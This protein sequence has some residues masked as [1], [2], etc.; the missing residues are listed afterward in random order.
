[1][2]PDPCSQ[3]FSANSAPRAVD[4]LV[5]F[6]LAGSFAQD[7]Q[8]LVDRHHNSADPHSPL[9]ERDNSSLST[10]RA[11]HFPP[12]PLALVA[13]RR[14]RFNARPVADT[15]LAVTRHAG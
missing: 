8:S 14:L 12:E 15:H 6:H 1:M 5:A 2:T 3:P 13:A 7:G 9:K 4:A 10:G 11:W